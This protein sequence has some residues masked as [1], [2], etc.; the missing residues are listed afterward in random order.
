MYQAKPFIYE[1]EIEWHLEHGGISLWGIGLQDVGTIISADVT[2]DGLVDIVD[3]ESQPGKMVV[4]AGTRRDGVEIHDAERY[5]FASAVVYDFGSSGQPIENVKIKTADFNADGLM[6]FAIQS[7]CDSSACIQ[8]SLRVYLAKRDELGFELRMF[9]YSGYGNLKDFSVAD[10]NGDGLTDIAYLVDEQWRYRLNTGPSFQEEKFVHDSEAYGADNVEDPTATFVDVNRDGA[11]DVVWKDEYI[12]YKMWL[13]K[14]QRFSESRRY[15]HFVNEN[16]SYAFIDFNGNSIINQIHVV[17]SQGNARN[18]GFDFDLPNSSTVGNPRKIEEIANGLG[19]KTE[20]HYGVLAGDTSSYYTSTNDLLNASE[21]TA[22]AECPHGELGRGTINVWH[23]CTTPGPDT[24]TGSYYTQINQPFSYLPPDRQSI[25]TETIAPVMEIHGPFTVVTQVDSSA[26]IEGNTEHQVSVAYHY[27]R[28]RYQAGGRGMLGFEKLRT[29]DLQSGVEVETTYRNDWPFIGVP[30]ESVT[31]TSGGDVLKHSII[32]SRILG[33]EETYASTFQSYGSAELGPLQIYSHSMVETKFALNNITAITS[34]VVTEATPDNFGNIIQVDVSTFTGGTS[35]VAE[36][37]VSTTN[38]YLSS[39]DGERLGRLIASEVTTS[40]PSS[41][42]HE[43]DQVEPVTRSST[44]TYYGMGDNTCENIDYLKG[45]ICSEATVGGLEKKHYYD[46][47]GNSTF[48]YSQ[49]PND[50]IGRLS[51]YS[52]YDSLGRYVDAIYAVSSASLNS[53]SF[54]G[55]NQYQTYASLITEVAPGSNASVVKTSQTTMRNKYGAP[56]ELESFTGQD[57]VSTSTKYSPFGTVVFTASDNG[58]FKVTTSSK[59]DVN[60]CPEGTSFSTI[61]RSAGSE[62]IQEKTC[63]DLAGRELRS[64]SVGFQGEWIAV[65]RL[66]DDRGRKARVSEP[67][68]LSSETPAWTVYDE[69]D[70]LDRVTLTTLPFFQ[71]NDNGESTGSLAQLEVAYLDDQAKVET[72]RTAN[73]GSPEIS[74]VE[75]RNVLGE[76]VAVTETDNGVDV[77]A[78][79]YYDALGNLTAVVDAVSNTTIIEYNEL[80]QKVA[81]ND[82]DIGISSYRYNAFGDLI[83]Q[84]NGSLDGNTPLA[85][86]DGESDSYTLLAS[87]GH[88]S[89]MQYDFAGRMI[90]RND[91][92]Q[93]SCDAPREEEGYASWVYDGGIGALGQLVGEYG[94]GG[95][96]K[97]IEY[98]KFGRV[99]VVSTTIPGDSVVTTGTHYEKTIYDEFG[100]VHVS[101]DAARDGADFSHSGVVNVYNNYGYLWKLEN[102]NDNAVEGETVYQEVESMDARGNVTSVSLAD[103][104]TYSQ[105]YFNPRTGLME[106]LST[107]NGVLEFQS[108]EMRWDTLGNLASRKD[109]GEISIANPRNQWEEFYYDEL[110]R[111]TSYIVNEDE[112]TRISIDYDILGNIESKSDVGSY[113]YNDFGPHAVSK[114]GDDSYYYDANGNLVQ[115]D[116]GRTFAYSTFDKVTEITK[117]SRSTQFS[118]GVDRTRYKRID[119]DPL[120]RAEVVTIYLGG[121][122]KIY[123]SGQSVQWK[124]RIGNIQITQSYEIESHS[125]LGIETAYFHYDHLG[126]INFITDFSGAIIEQM[127]FDPWGARR[128]PGDW[129]EQEQ[130]AL[131]AVSE[132]FF[133]DGDPITLRGFT[134]HEMVGEMGIIHMNG[135]IYD[136]KLA[137]FVQADVYVQN[138]TLTASL[139]RYSYV[140]NNPLN[141]TDPTGHLVFS[142]FIGAIVAAAE[143]EAGLG[144]ILMFFAGYADAASAGASEGNAFKMGLISWVSYMAFAGIGESFRAASAANAGKAGLVSFGGLELTKQQ[145]AGQILSHSFA[146]GVMSGL[147]GGKFG[148]GFISAFFTKATT[149][150]QLKAAGDLSGFADYFTGATV[151]ATIGGTVSAVTGGKFANGASTGAMQFL[152]NAAGGKSKQANA[153]KDAIK[154][155][156]ALEEKMLTFFEE[157]TDGVF[158]LTVDDINTIQKGFYFDVIEVPGFSDVGVVDQ[159]TYADTFLYEPELVGKLFSWRGKSY[160]GGEVNYLGVGTLAAYRNEVGHVPYAVWAWNNVKQDGSPHLVA[161]LRSP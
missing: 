55:D 143:V 112:N 90:F 14:E 113:E 77:V 83:C 8:D 25:D 73:V 106:W 38:S 54:S 42:D 47:F 39:D 154:N 28:G 139:N 23:S 123:N 68:F 29:T 156:R 50:G 88:V 15:G 17:H 72:S 62:A 134:G 63:F 59:R 76:T 93:G 131:R 13:P 36:Q 11:A 124:R 7:N 144:L 142:L 150:L 18:P 19:V 141:A 140:L 40:R 126:S 87:G 81:M 121:V 44:F 161:H 37:V 75:Q 49:D 12:K 104:K 58:A 128:L 155:Y 152:F 158:P 117:G 9:G 138:P 100:R 46:S 153:Q 119:K 129:K 130:E 74:K 57:W 160:Y 97:I 3:F 120:T 127:A 66:Y 116:T 157:N 1:G 43:G 159:Y 96:S 125:L 51:A 78:R 151:A 26:P 6:D 80:S 99:G 60:N 70:L 114:A 102:A 103:G 109:L 133:I 33:Y 48:I 85:I 2:S 22:A 108:M 16:K 98:D 84:S 111:L 89:I 146:G 67:Y 4:Y 24:I 107:S 41:F 65:D 122:E 136:P 118:Y 86:S 53:G 94:S 92:E 148:H 105:S 20:I 79:Y 32:D 82:P 145:V 91:Y 27:T 56:T 61:E 101:F 35:N 110:N 135:R 52:E 147:R 71:T 137:R 30:L 5:T 45:L 132:S 69:Y 64:L 10:I 31:K 21:S 95:F 115:D 34:T 149:N